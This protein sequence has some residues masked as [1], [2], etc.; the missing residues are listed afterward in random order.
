MEARRNLAALENEHA[1]DQ[2]YDTGSGFQVTEV[3]FYRTDRQREFPFAAECFRQRD[4]LDGIAH[5][6]ARAVGFDE[7][8][9]RWFDS[10]IG[11]SVAHQLGLGLGAREG[12]SVGMAVLVERRA[13]NH[14]LDR[15]AIRDGLGKRF[16]QDDARAFATDE[17]IRFG[18][19]RL[20]R[21]VRREH[22]RLGKADEAVRSDNHRH[23]TRHRHFA[24]PGTQR[25]TC[26]MH[27]GQCGGTSGVHRQAR[28]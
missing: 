15:I 24:T 17:A 16:Q 28:T 8:D 14:A 10:R 3:G 13:E 6:R 19:E 21:A 9:F 26:K 22:A 27:G 20:A 1:F 7:A 11:T 2:T 18:G 5:R 4:G 23:T 12:N 25:F